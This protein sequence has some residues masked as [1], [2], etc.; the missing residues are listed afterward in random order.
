MAW[1]EKLMG[2]SVR[3]TS[4]LEFPSSLFYCH[5]ERQP[6]HLVPGY[7]LARKDTCEE[8]LSVNPECVFTF[9]GEL[10][11]TISAQ[12]CLVEKFALQGTVVW[13]P[14]P[15]TGALQPFWLSHEL[16][17]AI[18]TLRSS[19]RSVSEIS[20]ENRHSLTVAGV[21]VKPSQVEAERSRW[22]DAIKKSAVAFSECGYVPLAELIHPF[23]VAALRRYYRQRVRTGGMVLG[24][25]QSSRRYVAHNDG[26]AR[27][28][29][30]QLTQV[31]SAVAG[32]T[33][34]PS[35]VY[36]ASYQGGAKLDVHTDRLQ[37]EFSI[38]FC[39]DYSPEPSLAT[40]WPL[41]L[42]TKSGVVTVYQAIGDALL[43]RGRALPH[44]RDR[45]R[46]GQ[47]STSIFF[48]YV[49]E[50]FPGPLD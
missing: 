29:H 30:R 22:A 16:H 27:F 7:V 3:A 21:L 45:L 14:H 28:F 15:A 5:L 11:P 40:P 24:D 38:T 4:A 10:P 44:S 26:V 13:V 18:Q 31:M 43:Y 39:L 25:G 12:E 8:E 42:H 50:D 9:D 34:K 36:A 20:S 49:R 1:M 37:C 46:Q 41:Q 33:V 17:E 48:H 6:D 47:T 23:H 19:Q 2:S 35:Y 32:E